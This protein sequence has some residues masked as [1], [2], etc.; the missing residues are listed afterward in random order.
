MI[1]LLKGVPR[2]H[3]MP[4]SEWERVHSA[5]YPALSFNPCEK[6]NA[7]FSPF[8][9]D[10]GLIV[11]SLYA[12][13]SIKA[14]LME[15]VFHETPVPSSG[16]L[17]V[18]R[19]IAERKWART[20]FTNTE[21]LRLVDL[22]TVGLQ[23]IGLTRPQVIDTTSAKYRSTQSFA[24]YLHAQFPDAHG[25]RW[26]SRLYDE[27]TCIVLYKDR[28]KSGMLVQLSPTT[29]VLEG[30]TLTHLLDLVDHLGMRYIPR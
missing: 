17:L 21:A 6:S 15:T 14:A 26:V 19:N 11:P 3:T 24:R 4:P 10:Q 16:S 13:S 1:F 2:L 12:G 22:T 29:G 9:D 30:A 23:R 5:D 7:R 8:S 18:E 27:G 20:T 28:I 25:I